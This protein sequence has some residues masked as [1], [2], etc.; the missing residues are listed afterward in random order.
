MAGAIVFSQNRIVSTL[1]KDG[2]CHPEEVV[3][4]ATLPTLYIFADGLSIDK[5]AVKK[6]FP[7]DNNKSI[8]E[9]MGMTGPVVTIRGYIAP[10]G[11]TLWKEVYS[12]DILTVK[13]F[14]NIIWNVT[15]APDSEWW[16]D[17]SSRD[18]RTGRR[19]NLSMR[20]DWNLT[21]H[22]KDE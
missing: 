21:L 5:L 19:Q 6:Y 10:A 11:L 9:P 15:L 2:E 1:E 20:Y 22:R 3:I 7:W 12:N 13:S 16:V 4:T 8:Y 14:D 17:T 18:T